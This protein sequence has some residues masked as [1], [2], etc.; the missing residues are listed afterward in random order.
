MAVDSVVVPFVP[1]LAAVAEVLVVLLDAT[2]ALSVVPVDV[3]LVVPAA[4]VLVAAPVPDS[5][6]VIS[7]RKESSPVPLLLLSDVLELLAP[8]EASSACNGSVELLLVL[9]EALC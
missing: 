3:P 5:M 2:V 7:L 9:L 1:V 6:A 4:D 8:S